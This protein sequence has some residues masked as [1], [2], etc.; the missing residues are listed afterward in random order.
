MA[1]LSSCNRDPVAS[2]PQIL[3]A[4]PLKEVCQPLGVDNFL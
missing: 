3:L 1:E 2:K 4:S